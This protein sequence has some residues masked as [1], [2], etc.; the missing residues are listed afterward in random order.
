MVRVVNPE[1]AEEYPICKKND[2]EGERLDAKAKC[3]YPEELS[4]GGA[5]PPSTP[6]AEEHT[7]RNKP[8]AHDD[9]KST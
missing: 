2:R 6:R 9:W 4:E 5:A 1:P 7:E 3:I 8:E